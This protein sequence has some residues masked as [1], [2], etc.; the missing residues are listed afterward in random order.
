MLREIIR[1]LLKVTLSCRSRSRLTRTHWGADLDPTDKWSMEACKGTR[2]RLW[3]Y[4]TTSHLSHLTKSVLILEM[5]KMLKS[6]DHVS[7]EDWRQKP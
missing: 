7:P 5:Q 1:P 2:L 4:H 6:A 3:L